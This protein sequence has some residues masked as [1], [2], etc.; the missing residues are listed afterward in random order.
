LTARD[1]YVFENGRLLPIAD[2]VPL[3]G[4]RAKA[5]EINAEYMTQQIRRAIFREP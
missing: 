3:D 5:A 4:L 1:G 2:A